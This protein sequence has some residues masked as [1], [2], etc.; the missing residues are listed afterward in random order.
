MKQIRKYGRHRKGGQQGDQLA[1]DQC[2]V[3]SSLLLL[4]NNLPLSTALNLLFFLLGC[5]YFGYILGQFHSAELAGKSI[6]STLLA[7]L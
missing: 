7:S 3:E 2:L 4:S 5:T 1:W 6:T